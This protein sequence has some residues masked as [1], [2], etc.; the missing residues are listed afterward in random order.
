MKR[1]PPKL[2]A[3]LAG[4]ALAVAATSGCAVRAESSATR[5][6]D[7]ALAPESLPAEARPDDEG[8]STSV[9]FL[10]DEHLETVERATEPT[11]AAALEALLRGPRETE[12]TAGLHTAIPAG[13]SLGSATVAGGVATIDLSEGLASVV[14]PE[15]VLAIA[16]LVYTAT[17]VE[18]VHEVVLA[19]EGQRIDAARGDGSLAAGAVDRADYPGLLDE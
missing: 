8:P 19:I 18:G 13:T 15:Q 5:L 11:L 14:G 4:A 10:R 16:Q 9:F 2:V 17:S 12:A 6:D 1:L 7:I 3:T